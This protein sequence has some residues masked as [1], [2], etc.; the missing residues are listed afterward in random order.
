MNYY[1]SNYKIDIASILCTSKKSEF[2]VTLHIGTNRKESLSLWQHKSTELVHELEGQAE[3]QYKKS[4][5]QRSPS[6]IR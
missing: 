6:L 5:C 2:C 4:M 1:A 3:A